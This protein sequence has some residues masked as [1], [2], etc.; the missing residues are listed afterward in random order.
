MS[1][2][3]TTCAQ[4]L[5]CPAAATSSVAA[6]NGRGVDVAPCTLN[7]ENPYANTI[8]RV[9]NALLMLHFLSIPYKVQPGLVAPK[10]F[11]RAAILPLAINGPGRVTKPAHPLSEE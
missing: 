3:H 11:S 6:S 10:S 9:Y 4:V 1:W 8:Q 2:D 7:D 5:G